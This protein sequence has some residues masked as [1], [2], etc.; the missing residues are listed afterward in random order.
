M[1]FLLYFSPVS[2]QGDTLW[3]IR[4]GQEMLKNK[5]VLRNDV[6]SWT[7]P[8]IPWTAHSWL[9]D[10]AAAALYNASG[11]NGL[12]LV[13]LLLGLA[14]G[15]AVF[16]M[17]RNAPVLWPL[18]ATLS[19]LVIRVVWCIRPHTVALV[20]FA[21]V[22]VALSEGWLKKAG[23]KELLLT[24]VWFALWA[25]VHSSVTAG[26]LVAAVYAL[27]GMASGKHFIAGLV[28]M[29]ATP[30]F[31]GIFPYSWR[32]SSSPEIVNRI[33]EWL[34]PNFHEAW[35]LV[36]IVSA[37][38]VL[39]L[40][41]GAWRPLEIPGKK[42]RVK[43]PPLGFVLA[44]LGILLYLKSVRHISMLVLLMAAAVRALPDEKGSGD[45][46]RRAWLRLIAA[47]ALL[48][49]VLGL[50]FVRPGETG[51]LFGPADVERALADDPIVRAVD[52]MVATGRTD[53]VLNEYHIGDYLIWRG[54]KP[55]IDGRADM[56]V[57]AKPAFWE[58]YV[59][60]VLQGDER[61]AEEVLKKYGVKRIIFSKEKW[62]AW[63]AGKLPG[64]TRV[65]ENEAVVVFDCDP[66]LVC[67]QDR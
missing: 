42:F 30:Q 35:N 7:A 2:Y 67:P 17:T 8:G 61:P 46:E 27:Y 64:V 26:L 45:G 25:N 51:K 22:L 12:W 16:F 47:G 44:S 21:S 65:Y 60:C 1:L 19:M 39:S 36:A 53:R 37:L 66:E 43:V 32:A 55:F 52:F 18:F 54:V 15:M 62:F 24:A 11:F 57:F 20:M 5:A 38:V 59:D 49:A 6:F 31:L 50:L 10:V 63:Y 3:H 9:Y 48:A 28:G 58:D 33:N 13:T 14:Y 34:S 23:G 4:A 41:N 29:L 40:A 56:Y